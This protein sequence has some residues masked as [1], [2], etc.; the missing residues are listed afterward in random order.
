MSITSDE[1]RPDMRAVTNLLRL[2]ARTLAGR[3]AGRSASEQQQ[4]VSDEE[5]ERRLS[6]AW[7]LVQA[8]AHELSKPQ[9]TMH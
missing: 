2:A 3:P 6:A 8:A 9:P 5:L 4:P 7:F 1:D